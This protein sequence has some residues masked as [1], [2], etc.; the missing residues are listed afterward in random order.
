MRFR[1]PGSRQQDLFGQLNHARKMAERVT[2]L[3]RLTAAVDFE[4]FRDRLVEMLV[5]K[6]RVDKG[7]QRTLR[8]RV[9]V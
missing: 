9:H 7:G 4:M 1:R 2:S 8:P 5:Y 3:D 6:D